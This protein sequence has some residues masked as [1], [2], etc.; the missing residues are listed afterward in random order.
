MLILAP[1]ASPDLKIHVAWHFTCLSLRNAMVSLLMLLA[2]CDAGANV[3]K[4]PKETH[5]I[6]FQLSLPKEDSDAI[7][8]DVDIIWHWYW[9]PLHCMMPTPVAVVS[10]DQKAILCLLQYNS[11]IVVR[12]FCGSLFPPST[13]PSCPIGHLPLGG[14]HI[15]LVSMVLP[16]V[17][18]W[19][20][21]PPTSILSPNFL[22]SSWHQKLV[23]ITISLRSEEALL[24]WTLQKLFHSA[25]IVFCFAIILE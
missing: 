9:S 16:G 10:H 24:I 5:S 13:S 22:P 6:S 19:P 7:Y 15:S 21:F 12:K 3:V 23:V 11:K 17:T 18:Y 4:W 14:T 8:D 2:L 1:M 25:N 20:L